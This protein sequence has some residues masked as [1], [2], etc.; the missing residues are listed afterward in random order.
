MKKLIVLVIAI[1]LTGY[2]YAGN[3]GIF[4]KGYQDGYK[5]FK[6]LNVNIKDKNL[7]VGG[8]YFLRMT[9]CDKEVLTL[10]PMGNITFGGD[11][12][13][14]ITLTEL[15]RCLRF[16]AP[17]LFD[18]KVKEIQNKT[19]KELKIDWGE[20]WGS[21]ITLSPDGLIKK[22]LGLR[23]DGIVVWREGKQKGTK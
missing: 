10:T 18:K 11:E 23:E 20:K 21:W 5:I 14:R 15:L 19:E 9:L 17:D 3:K 6:D 7:T 2:V 13:N 8:E 22:D 1:C 4:I 12:S 16:I